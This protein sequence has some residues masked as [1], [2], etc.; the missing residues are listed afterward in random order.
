MHGHM[1]G[2]TV[3]MICSRFHFLLCFLHITPVHA[4]HGNSLHRETVE[5]THVCIFGFIQP[6]PFIGKILPLII[7]EDDGLF[8]RFLL[9]APKVSKLTV[10]EVAESIQQQMALP[11]QMR[12]FTAVLQAINNCHDC[13]GPR[14]YLL[15]PEALRLYSQFESEQ[16]TQFNDSW[17]LDNSGAGTKDTRY[18]LR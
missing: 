14:K 11:A 6:F 2:Y 18:I 9:C 17:G 4:G 13:V 3:Y 16:V 7:A 1:A 5:K 12:D 15:T 10:N 8:D